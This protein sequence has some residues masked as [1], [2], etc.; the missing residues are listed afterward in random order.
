MFN[1][2]ITLCIVLNTVLL[3]MDKYPIHKEE[4]E[5]QQ[6]FNNILSWIF[7]GEMILKLIGL[8]FKEYA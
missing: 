8:G 4:Y 3:A 2:F 7:F 1:V 6:M 5:M